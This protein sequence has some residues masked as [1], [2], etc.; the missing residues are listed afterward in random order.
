MHKDG[1]TIISSDII[2]SDIYIKLFLDQA[3]PAWS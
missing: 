2:I 3:D 1:K